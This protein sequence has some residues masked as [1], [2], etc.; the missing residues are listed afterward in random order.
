[1]KLRHF[2]PCLI[3]SGSFW[4]S[5]LSA[6]LPLQTVPPEIVLE[7]K[8]GSRVDTQGPW[9]SS[10]LKGKI[11]VLFYVA[12]SMKDLNKE[13]SEAIKLEA[14]PTEQFGSV[15]VINMAASSW[16][17]WLLSKKLQQSQKEFPRTIYVEDRTRELARVWKLEDDS[18]DILVFDKEGRVIFS[19]DGKLS[20]EGVQNLVKLIRS[21]ING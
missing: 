18:N 3:L 1:M 14:F 12:P 8:S 9:T 4:N 20:T 2:I 15:A 6:T 21:Q 10:S 17:N 13:A 16:P 5:P 7:G 11:H 19:H